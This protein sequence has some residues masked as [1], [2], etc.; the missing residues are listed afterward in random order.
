MSWQ[1][2]LLTRCCSC[3]FGGAAAGRRMQGCGSTHTGTPSFHRC[4][5]AAAWF[6]CCWCRTCHCR[7]RL[8]VKALDD[9]PARPGSTDQRH[10]Q[11]GETSSAPGEADCVLA[12]P[13]PARELTS[14]ECDELGAPHALLVLQR[15]RV[16]NMLQGEGY[17]RQC[18]GLLQRQRDAFV[19]AVIHSRCRCRQ[20]A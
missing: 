5:C 10:L 20:S 18:R 6:L 17:E 7:G 9:H 12:M 2:M 13:E 8:L 3:A 15:S 19:C 4:T 1:A 14:G 11:A 16:V